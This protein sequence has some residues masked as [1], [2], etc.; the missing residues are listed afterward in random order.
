LGLNYYLDQYVAKITSL[1]IPYLVDNIKDF[2]WVKLQDSL[3]KMLGRIYR[4][5]HKEERKPDADKE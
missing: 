2:Q 3:T 5:T 1:F 4:E